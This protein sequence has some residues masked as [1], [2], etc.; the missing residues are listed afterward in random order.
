MGNKRSDLTQED[1]IAWAD[2]VAGI[3]QQATA[4]KLGVH[5]NTVATKRRKVADFIAEKFDINEYRM[6]LYGLY[7]LVINSMIHNL[8]KNDVTMTIAVAKGLQF[9]V[10]KNQSETDNRLN[11]SNDELAERIGRSVGLNDSAK[12]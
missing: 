1:I 7:P 11:L 4:D 10:D 9:L 6:P 12:G 3:K 8:K 5:V 2:G